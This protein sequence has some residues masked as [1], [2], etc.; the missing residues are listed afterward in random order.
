MKLSD[1][2]IKFLEDKGIEHIFMLSGGGCLHLVDSVGKSNLKYV[3]NLHEQAVAIAGEAYAQYTNKP[4][5]CLVTTGPG[6]TNTITGVASAWLDSI[7]M[8]MISGQVQSKD[9]KGLRRVRQIGFQ[10]IDIV[11]IVKPITK[12]AQTVKEP[13]R[14]RTIL[15]TAYHE[16]STGRQGPV[17]IDIP[18]DIQAATVNIEGYPE[19]PPPYKKDI[20]HTVKAIAKLIQESK[21]PIIMAGNG[22]RSANAIEEF[23]TLIDKLQIPVL[24]TWKGIDL[25]E[26]DHPLFVG[27]PGIA[28]QRGA[29]FSQQNADLFISIGARLDHGQTAFNHENFAKKAK[30]V[31]VDIDNSEIDKL[32]FD[33]EYSMNVD[34][35]HFIDELTTNVPPFSLPERGNPPNTWWLK[36]CKQWQS[37]YPVCLPEYYRQA[38]RINN[39]VFIE[40]LS[41]LM[42]PT[43]LLI[44][45]SSGACSEI[46]MQAFKVK[47]GQRIFNSEGLGS[48][49]FGIAASIG[50]CIASDKR[51][52]I[53][54]DGDGGFIMNVQELETVRRLNLPI[55]FFVLNN[56]GYVSIR[57]S[58]DKHFE[59]RVASSDETGVTLPELQKIS[60]SYDLPYYSV[61]LHDDLHHII[62]SVL[63]HDGPAICEI[64]ML[65]TQETLPRTS[66]KK[67]EDGSFSSAPMEDLYPFLDRQEFENNM[68]N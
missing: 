11:S 16:A 38:Y 62:K 8:I 41:D 43:D 50:G 31:I 51:H 46:T 60:R 35:K 32:G 65:P 15:E 42:L 39:Y 26:E 64:H 14:I 37:N 58:Q 29:N 6:G 44:P 48:M 2:V 36:Q 17:W 68:K 49:G 30:K 47:K 67:N 59:Q 9:M 12:Y 27:R 33:I 5:V 40:T 28:A 55:K 66:T 34:A 13:D 7:P 1:Y 18:L 21:R 56:S 61:Y 3:C 24:T 10:E 20:K 52:T 63:N 54:V 23:Y 22:I 53:C 45:G 25:L 57:N 19:S 4:S